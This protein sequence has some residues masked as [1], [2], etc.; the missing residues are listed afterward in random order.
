MTMDLQPLPE[1]DPPFT[2]DDL[3]EYLDWEA[4]WDEGPPEDDAPPG[5]DK[6]LAWSVCDTGS[7]E[8]AFRRLSNLELAAAEARAAA[9]EW[10]AQIDRWERGQLVPLERSINFFTGQIEAYARRKREEEGQKSLKLPSG[11]VTSRLNPARAEVADPE[12]FIAWAKANC[13]S[14]VKAK[15]SPVM[16]E[17]KKLVT[18]V[19]TAVGLV[20][21]YGDEVVHG[22]T[23]VP[24][25]VSYS[26]KPNLP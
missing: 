6:V 14:A 13:P 25:D 4:T 2:D 26:I 7:A 5:P 19:E 11:E 9:K 3:N 16:A 20:P 24:E 22:L 10:R 21:L 23:L 8:W 1:V 12:E 17:V 15:W 18:W